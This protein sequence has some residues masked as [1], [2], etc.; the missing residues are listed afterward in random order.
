MEVGKMI[1]HINGF[2]VMFAG[3]GEGSFVVVS[4]QT[5]KSQGD[6]QL[7]MVTFKVG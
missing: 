3:V 7:L 5:T 6:L 2:V 1:A 4:H